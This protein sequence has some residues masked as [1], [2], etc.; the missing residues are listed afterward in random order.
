[1]KAAN[2]KAKD[3]S[4]RA[5]ERTANIDASATQEALTDATRRLAE[6]SEQESRV[7]AQRDRLVAALSLALALREKRQTLATTKGTLESLGR[8]IRGNDHRGDKGARRNR[9][10]V[11]LDR[12]HCQADRR[13]ALRWER[14][15]SS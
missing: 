10:R 4:I 8:R 3:A 15:S 13:Y 7:A 12:G 2:E 14:T 1:M 9:Q 6:H 11:R 5:E